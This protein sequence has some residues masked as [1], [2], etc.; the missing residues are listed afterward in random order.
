MHKATQESDYPI[1]G[2]FLFSQ[3]QQ[4]AN[5]SLLCGSQNR[6]ILRIKA[7]EAEGKDHYEGCGQF[8]MVLTGLIVSQEV[9]ME[10][11]S[12]EVRAIKWERLLW[13]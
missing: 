2:K 1:T 9:G 12:A 7:E 13:I 11:D 10:E 8:L 3:L 6:L 5:S 4:L